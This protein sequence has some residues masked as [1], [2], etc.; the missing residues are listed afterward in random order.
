MDTAGMNFGQVM[1][2]IM[3]EP[4]KPTEAKPEDDTKSVLKSMLTENTG[5][6]LLDSGG[7]YGRAFEKN[8]GVEDWDKRPAFNLE[9]SI[10]E[11]GQYSKKDEGD[12]E[13]SVMASIDLYHWLLDRLE[14]APEMDAAFNEFC[15]KPENEREH[16]LGLAEAFGES[17]NL[18]PHDRQFTVN[19][20]NGE[21]ALSQII[22]YTVFKDHE[23]DEYYCILSIHGGCDVRGGYT[24]PRLFH[25]YEPYDLM[26]N[27]QFDLVCDGSGEPDHNP[28]QLNIDNELYVRERCRANWSTENGGY[29]FMFDGGYPV[30][31]GLD[32]GK[33]PVERGTEGKKNV[34]V[35]DEDENCAYCPHCG[36]GKIT[37]YPPFGPS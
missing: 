10:Y 2:E 15:D 24:K 18:E 37:G 26:D 4:G 31:E 7:A 32:L 3:S 12:L 23:D 22:Q 11:A 8:Q 14:Y 36:K 25:M 34:L 13:M 33:I 28:G 9:W 27:A 16:Y 5:R 1:A 17:R 6:H 29:E 21:D 19:T 35:I 30:P 20:Y